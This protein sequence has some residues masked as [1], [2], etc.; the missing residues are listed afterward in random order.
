MLCLSFLPY[1]FSSTKSEKKKVEQVLPRGGRWG[2]AVLEWREKVV[3]KEV[4]G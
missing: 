1:I 2:R 3:R 4:G